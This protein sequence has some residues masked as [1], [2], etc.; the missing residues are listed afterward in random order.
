MAG[1]LSLILATT[2]VAAATNNHEPRIK[3]TFPLMQKF[4]SLDGLI[5]REHVRQLRQTAI[6][7]GEDPSSILSTR[8]IVDL[9]ADNGFDGYYATIGVGSQTFTTL[10][11]DTGSANTWINVTTPFTQGVTVEY[12]PGSTATKT[13]YNFKLIYGIGQIR[14]DQYTDT[15]KIHGSNGVTLTATN[16]GI[17]AAKQ[18]SGF[19]GSNG[20]LAL[21][22]TAGG[23]NTIY[24]ADGSAANV[25]Y[26]T[27]VDTLFSEGQI[28]ARKVGLSFV[29]T[30]SGNGGN[31]IVGAGTITFGGVNPADYI[32]TINYFPRVSVSGYDKYW[33]ISV[34]S[35]TYQHEGTHGR[36]AVDSLASASKLGFI[37]SGTTLAYLPTDVYNQYVALTGAY[38]NQDSGL[39]VIP[40]A[41]VPEMGNMTMTIA[42]QDY[43]LTPSAQLMPSEISALFS[44]GATPDQS[45]EYLS[46]FGESFFDD[47]N[48]FVLGM[49]FLERFYSV[50]DSDNGLIGLA[51]TPYTYDKTTELTSFR[52]TKRAHRERTK[53][54]EW[55][56]GKSRLSALS[57]RSPFFLAK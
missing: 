21:G 9:P 42:G 15:V 2:M 49:L 41:N 56:D 33:G 18:Q 30:T 29:P 17:G 25:V 13:P 31:K 10:L 46:I 44:N 45:G 16:Q 20:V 26:P 24:N 6:L 37:D 53:R 47:G 48:T 35:V 51:E 38:I 52:R 34:D 22:P 40:S 57:A 19:D 54:T 27:I 28:P 39:L 12:Q 36:E 5:E 11:V 8:A 32:G 3:Q 55:M 1:I 4:G 23:E 14:G 50:F 43:I 7:Y